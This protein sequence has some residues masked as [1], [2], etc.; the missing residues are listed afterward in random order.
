MRGFP[1]V[2]I[3]LYG[4]SCAIAIGCHEEPEPEFAGQACDVA[5]EC[6]P[7]LDPATLLGEIECL[8]TNGGGYCTHECVSDDECCA[9]EGECVSGYPQVCA[10]YTNSTQ[11]RCFLACEDSDVGDLGPDEYCQTYAH[12]SFGCR[13]TG[14][15]SE[16]RKVCVP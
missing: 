5:S 10:P 2:P 7:D 16:N 4:F 8:E 9:V 1:W 3:M 12:S 11:K 6:Y 13:S 15:G 14:G